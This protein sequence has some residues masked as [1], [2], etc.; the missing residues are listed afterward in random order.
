MHCCRRLLNHSRPLKRRKGNDGAIALSLPGI[1]GNH[2]NNE[3]ITVRVAHDKPAVG[4][5]GYTAGV[6]E[7]PGTW[8]PSRY[9]LNEVSLEIVCFYGSVSVIKNKQSSAAIEIRTA[10]AVFAEFISNPPWCFDRQGSFQL[11]PLPDSAGFAIHAS[12]SVVR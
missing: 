7:L 6:H 11:P 1:Q 3:S 4:Q 12:T 2:Q 5:F 8:P 10:H 9:H